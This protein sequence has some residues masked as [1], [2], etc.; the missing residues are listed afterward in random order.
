VSAGAGSASASM[1]AAR[2]SATGKS[3]KSGTLSTRRGKPPWAAGI[4]SS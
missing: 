3:V 1:S 4:R 2:S